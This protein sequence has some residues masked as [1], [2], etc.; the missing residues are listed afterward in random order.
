MDLLPSPGLIEELI[1][2]HREGNFDRVMGFMQLMFFVEESYE[3]E[4]VQIPEPNKA[5]TAL[6]SKM[7]TMFKKNR[8]F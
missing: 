5:A 8:R 3:Q 7:G 4:L 6:I 1:Q 2:Y